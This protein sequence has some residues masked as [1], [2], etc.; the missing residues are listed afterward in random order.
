ME[1]KIHTIKVRIIIVLFSI[2]LVIP[3]AATTLFAS[4]SANQKDEL[5]QN[6]PELQQENSSKADLT[7]TTDE[8]SRTKVVLQAEVLSISTSPSTLT[9]YLKNQLGMKN[10]PDALTQEQIEQFK[11]WA[12]S[13]PGTAI[14]SDL[15][16]SL[17]PL[18]SQ[19]LDAAK[20]NRLITDYEID[21]NSPDKYKPKYQTY[22]TGI[23]L[24]L[25]PGSINKD[26]PVGV[27]I[28]LRKTDITKVQEKLH[29]SGNTIQ[30]PEFINSNISTQ[31]SIPQGKYSLIATGGLSSGIVTESG[32][33]QPDNQTII[34]IKLQVKVE[35]KPDPIS[36]FEKPLVGTWRSSGIGTNENN[37]EVTSYMI[38][39]NDRSWFQVAFFGSEDIPTEISSIEKGPLWFCSR[40]RL[41]QFFPTPPNAGDHLFSRKISSLTP[42]VVSFD[43]GRPA[44]FILEYKRVSGLAEARIKEII[45]QQN[46][47]NNKENK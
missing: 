20:Q 25:I 1:I 3:S 17:Y 30:I 35:D 33:D 15:N 16:A 40:E 29:P 47:D 2:F 45:A 38:L 43:T 26:E 31:V 21:S 41:M 11:N 8:K 24:S 10:I 13:I 14:T 28:N 9:D 19:N 5:A 23:E 22:T 4:D 39:N 27:S 32:F 12:K 42:S 37:Q 46:Q 36:S 6:E 7:I 18:Q 44:G 34:L